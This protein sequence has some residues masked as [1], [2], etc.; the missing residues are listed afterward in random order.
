MISRLKKKMMNMK[1]N[2]YLVLNC[3]KCGHYQRVNEP[4][5][6]EKWICCVCG[7]SHKM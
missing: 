2:D 1:S 7:K 4:L 5:Y 6:K 3:W